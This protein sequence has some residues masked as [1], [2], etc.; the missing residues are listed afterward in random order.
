MTLIIGT[1]QA[2][3]DRLRLLVRGHVLATVLWMWSAGR[4]A[5]PGYLREIYAPTSDKTSDLQSF[6][7]LL[8]CQQRAQLPP[9]AAVLRRALGEF[10]APRLLPSSPANSQYMDSCG[11]WN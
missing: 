1:I 10:Y 9:S 4:P 6:S 7:Y 8:L 11:P 2:R 3:A 5:A